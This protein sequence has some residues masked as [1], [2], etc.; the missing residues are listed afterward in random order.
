MGK[1]V[2]EDGV[3]TQ[4]SWPFFKRGLL[5]LTFHNLPIQY[6]VTTLS[7]QSITHPRYAGPNYVYNILSSNE[8]T[9]YNHLR[10]WM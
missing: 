8:R 6:I 3:L 7:T 10:R 9:T 4:S 5:F 1:S 2:E